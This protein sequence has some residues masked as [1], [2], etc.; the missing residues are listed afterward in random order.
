MIVLNKYT[1]S[2]KEYSSKTKVKKGKLKEGT[3][4]DKN[5]FNNL[6][7]AKEFVTLLTKLAKSWD[8]ATIQDWDSLTK[9]YDD[10]DFFDM[11]YN[12]VKSGELTKSTLADSML[13]SLSRSLKPHSTS[14]PYINWNKIDPKVVNELILQLR[15]IRGEY[16]E[17]FKSIPIK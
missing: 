13:N 1:K 5:P 17:W 3:M 12:E 7:N 15:N 14:N 11:Y 4:S 8:K 16:F 2:L 6:Q 9:F 10:D